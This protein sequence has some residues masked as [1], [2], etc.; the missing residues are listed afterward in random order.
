MLAWPYGSPAV[1]SSY[2]FGHRDQG[3]PQAADGRTSDTT[4]YTAGWRCEHRWRVVANMVGFRN[5]VRGTPVV[6]WWDNGNDVIAFGRGD[7][8]YL[9]L[10]DEG[11]AVTGRR[12]QTRLP[13]GRYCD[14]VHGELRGGACTGPVLTVDAGGWFAA[15]LAPHDAVALHAGARL[16]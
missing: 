13:A 15:D 2:E 9:A 5:A 12:W 4:C 6:N 8:G 10:N 14:V 11:T 16:G 7:R 3:P 1:M